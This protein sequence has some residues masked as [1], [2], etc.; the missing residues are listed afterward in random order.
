MLQKLIS[1]LE[2]IV[3]EM[4]TL[5]TICSNIYMLIKDHYDTI[6]VQQQQN[7]HQR[8]DVEIAD[9]IN[10]ITAPNIIPGRVITPDIID[11]SFELDEEAIDDPTSPYSKL[12]STLLGMTARLKA[13]DVDVSSR[14]IN[15][16]LLKYKEVDE[17]VFRRYLDGVTGLPDLKNMS[18]LGDAYL[19]FILYNIDSTVVAKIGSNNFIC[20]EFK[21]YS[22]GYGSLEKKADKFEATLGYLLVRK[23]FPLMLI[24]RL[25]PTSDRKIQELHHIFMNKIFPYFKGGEYLS[26]NIKM[27]SR[28]RTGFNMS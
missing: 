17:S 26:A 16:S 11:P 15:Q 10:E 1:L 4:R 7:V 13:H 18:Y 19:F 28:A 22:L 23:Y 5:V 25:Y 20:N 14:A 8:N 9:S 12:Q 2:S 6:V 27:K 3:V 21:E 24:K